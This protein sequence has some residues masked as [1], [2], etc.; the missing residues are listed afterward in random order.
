MVFPVHISIRSVLKK[1]NYIYHQRNTFSGVL[2][3]ASNNVSIV[4]CRFMHNREDIGGALVA[5]YCNLCIDRSAYNDNT[6]TDYGGAMVTSGSVI[7][8]N[9]S[10][11]TNNTDMRVRER[12]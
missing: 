11:F 1:L 9:N 7:N 4:S 6:A 3:S 8:I 10:I 12:W 2:Y 5:Q